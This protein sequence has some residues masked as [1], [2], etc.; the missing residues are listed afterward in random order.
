MSKIVNEPVTT[1]N[2]KVN[3]NR[4][5]I[6]HRATWMGLMMD[7]A[8]KAGIDLVPVARSA[9]QRCGCFH[10]LNVYKKNMKKPEDL[11][12]FAEVFS[13]ELTLK[14]FDMEIMKRTE[15]EFVLHFHYCPLVNAWKKQGLSDEDIDLYCDIA[16]DGDRK[17][18][19]SFDTFDF[20]LNSTIAKGNKVCEVCFLKKKNKK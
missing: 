3:I 12:S 14:S 4:N 5:A 7:E 9:I 10:G 15:E 20:A 11:L 2:E 13:S 16:M 6:E 19:A 17:I 1:D 18:A 8:K